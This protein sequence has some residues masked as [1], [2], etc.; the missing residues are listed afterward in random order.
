MGRSLESIIA[1]NDMPEVYAE[2]LRRLATPTLQERL[3]RLMA[4]AGALAPDHTWP[5]GV[6]DDYIVGWVQGLQSKAAIANRTR[7]LEQELERSYQVAA[8]LRADLD[9]LQKQ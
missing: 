9:V 6:L 5:G 4:D 7:E 1:Q 2:V 8:D 3:Y